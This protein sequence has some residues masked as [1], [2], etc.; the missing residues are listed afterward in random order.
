MHAGKVSSCPEGL[1]FVEDDVGVTQSFELF[2]D[3]ILIGCRY[4]GT[5]VV[6]STPV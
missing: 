5:V 3:D 4:A 2:F 6:S 1:F